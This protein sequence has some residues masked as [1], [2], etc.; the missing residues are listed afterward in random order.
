VLLDLHLPKL[1]GFGVLERLRADERT[2]L[3]PVII[4]SSSGQESDVSESQRLGANGY[5]RKPS[6]FDALRETLAQLERD[7]LKA[8]EPPPGETPS[9]KP[10]APEKFQNSKHQNSET[11]AGAN[12]AQ[13]GF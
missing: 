2:R 5:L 4:L 10:Q 12:G 13:V 6:N 9:T 1:N 3:L 8:A 7:W 11:G